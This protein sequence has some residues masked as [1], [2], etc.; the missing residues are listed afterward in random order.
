MGVANERL[1]GLAVRRVNLVRQ[2]Y[3]LGVTRRSVCDGWARRLSLTTPPAARV[4][5]GGALVGVWDFCAA[6][7]VAGL[8]W[9][10][11]ALVLRVDLVCSARDGCVRRAWGNVVRR[12]AGR[13]AR[14]A[15]HFW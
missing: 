1:V 7:P 5:R 15:D 12:A 8:G 9:V 4:A 14:E 10:G 2:G 11:S 6:T 3:E 13:V